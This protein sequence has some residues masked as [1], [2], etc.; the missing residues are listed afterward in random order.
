MLARQLPGAI[1]LRVADRY[2]AGRLAEHQLGATVHVLDDG[3]QH[4]QLDR[5]VDI[6]LVAAAPISPTAATLPRG[7][8]RE[9][10]TSLVARRRDRRARRRRSAASTCR[11]ARSFR[12]PHG[13]PAPSVVRPTGRPPTGRRETGARARRHRRPGSRFFAAVRDRRL[14]GRWRRS[15]SAIT[16]RTRRGDVARIFG[17]ARRPARLAVV[18]T[19]KDY[20]RLL[21]H[22]PFPVP[23]G[24][25]AAYNGA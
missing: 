2:L 19:E 7:R 21:P 6:V 20:V 8:L 18:T 1:V 22:R 23:V 12:A 5:D 25:G 11:T 17:E 15:R 13:E 4:L 14:D 9:P 16:T 3:F 10:P 24:V